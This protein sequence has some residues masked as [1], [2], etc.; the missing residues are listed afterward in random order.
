[1]TELLQS[2]AG[3]VASGFLSAIEVSRIAGV[4]P[5]SVRRH[6]P[7]VRLGR[8]WLFA[9]EDVEARLGYKLPLSSKGAQ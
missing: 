4:S 6:F 9:R 5:N 1:M 3:P 7:S 8:R 2:S